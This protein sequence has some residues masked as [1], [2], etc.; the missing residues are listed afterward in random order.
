MKMIICTLLLLMLFLFST[1]LKLSDVLNDEV[2]Y[3]WEGND[4]DISKKVIL[5]S[6]CLIESLDSVTKNALMVR[7][8]AFNLQFGI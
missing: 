3:S 4:R 2:I 7:Q 5:L 6:S 1:D 8:I